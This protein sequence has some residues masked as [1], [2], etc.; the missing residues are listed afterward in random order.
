MSF[1]PVNARQPLPHLFLT[2]AT[3]CAIIVA[4]L[5][6]T[7]MSAGHAQ[8]VAF[9]PLD[10]D[11]GGYGDYL[12]AELM[13]R[14]GV[15]TRPA[16]WTAPALTSLQ[17]PASGSGLLVNCVTGLSATHGL[18]GLVDG[19]VI[20]GAN[21]QSIALIAYDGA[22]GAQ[23]AQLFIP[24]TGGLIN[25]PDLRE[26]TRTLS[27]AFASRTGGGTG[28]NPQNVQSRQPREPRTIEGDAHRVRVALR[29]QLVSRDLSIKQPEGT[30]T[31]EAPFYPGLT[32]QIAAFPIAFFGRSSPASALGLAVEFGKHSVNTVTELVVDEVNYDYSIPTRHDTTFFSLFYEG[33]VSDNFT[34]IPSVGWRVVTYALGNN[35][36]YSSSFYRGLDIELAGRYQLS[37]PASLLAGVALRP[38][39]SVGSTG[40]AYGD[41]S[42]TFGF[43]LRGEF[44]YALPFGLFADAGLHFNRYTTTY[45]GNVAGDT[46]ANDSFLSFIFAVGYA[47]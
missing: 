41:E 15:S 31:F 42:S 29:T 39:V 45:K 24:L 2:S 46:E 37:E 26:A 20:G 7:P 5:Y 3:R 21:P 19:T 9:A 34:L 22:T 8:D 18:A 1:S 17:C 33:S 6:L 43:G 23:V 12:A 38:A 35:P 30:V 44:R 47:Y 25:D 32:V 14:E 13:R 36:L 40:E 16:S 27:S 4:A 10:G 28:R 11:S